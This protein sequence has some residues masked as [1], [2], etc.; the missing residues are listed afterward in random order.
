MSTTDYS[1]VHWFSV[2]LIVT[3]AWAFMIFMKYTQR[4]THTHTYIY[5]YIYIHHLHIF[6]W[7]KF[8]VFLISSRNN[9][10]YIYL[11]GQ[12][13]VWT[14]WIASVK[15]VAHYLLTMDKNT[16]WLDYLVFE[17]ALRL[18]ILWYSGVWPGSSAT[19]WT[20]YMQRSHESSAIIV[21]GQIWL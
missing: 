16:D 20:N 8:N 2:E 7:N 15:P 5:I 6:K 9:Y 13:R 3:W 11:I 17:K 18:V 1:Y 10:L 14:V 4:H 12:L 19:I 21:I